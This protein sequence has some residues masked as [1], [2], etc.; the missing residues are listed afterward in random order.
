M[1]AEL[2]EFRA[3]VD[4]FLQSH[5]PSPLDAGHRDGFKGLDYYPENETYQKRSQ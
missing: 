1:T 4:D 2:I 3:Q 5:P